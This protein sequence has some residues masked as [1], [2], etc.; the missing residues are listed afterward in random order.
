MNKRLISF[1]FHL[2]SDFMF[3]IIIFHVLDLFSV[4]GIGW[5][6]VFFTVVVIFLVI[7]AS[8]IVCLLVLRLC[9]PNAPMWLDRRGTSTAYLIFPNN[10]TLYE[11]LYSSVS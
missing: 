4:W 9:V 3:L 8:L 2:F 10:R 6:V 11:W 1:V 7:V 5:F